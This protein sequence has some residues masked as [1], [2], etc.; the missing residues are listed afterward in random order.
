LEGVVLIAG[1][2][3]PETARRFVEDRA[4]RHIMVTFGR[5]F[6]ANPDLVYRVKKG[7]DLNYYDRSTFYTLKEPKGYLDYPFSKEY[8]ASVESSIE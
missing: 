1:G 6:I 7:L 4:D 3:T 5:P 2:F 8:V